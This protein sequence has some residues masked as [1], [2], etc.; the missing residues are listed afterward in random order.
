MPN[1]LFASNSVSHFPGSAIGAPAWSYDSNRV[2]Y[3][4]MC[5]LQT[6]VGSPAIADSST[7]EWWFHFRCGSNS[8]YVNNNE[9]VFEIADT[10]GDRIFLLSY[11][12]RNT[13]GFHSYFTVDGTEYTSVRYLPFAEDQARTFDIQLKFTALNAELRVYMNEILIETFVYPVTS[14]TRPGRFF[15]GGALGN[16]G[17][18]QTYY[19]ELIV[20]DGDTRNARLD[21]LR[22]ASV[23]AYSD[24]SGPVASLSDD[25]PTTGMTTV[26]ANDL[27]STVLT[28]YSGANNVSN[29]VQITTSV[30]GI[31]SPTK[32]QHLIRMSGVDHLTSSFDVPFSK[33]YQITD[34]AENPATSLPWAAD[35][36]AAAEFGFKSIA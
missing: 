30:R 36:L 1:I 15:L 14:W 16:Q 11:H 5:E 31:N 29:V 17:T 35:D 8:W 12:D 28:P 33:D 20:A 25:D 34:W 9:P 13:E 19:S 3:S 24:W 7:D 23:G 2:P 6:P 4:I 27:Q 22:P 21:L 18:G 26:D 32:L 10:D